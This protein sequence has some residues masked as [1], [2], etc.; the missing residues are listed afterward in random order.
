MESYPSML[1]AIPTYDGKILAEATNSLLF[2]VA[3]AQH[4][5]LDMAFTY[6][7]GCALVD[8]V[9]DSMAHTFLKESYQK[10]LMIDADIVFTPD[11]ILRILH[12]SRDYPIIGA[13]YPSRVELANGTSRYYLRPKD[14]KISY[15]KDG[16]LEVDGFGAGFLCVDK[17][18]FE[19]LASHVPQYSGGF[20]QQ[21][22]VAD[23]EPHHNFFPIG[24]D[25]LGAHHGE[26]YGFF[27]LA[28][29]YGFTPVVDLD[30]K[31]GH[32]GSKVYRGDPRTA[33]NSFKDGND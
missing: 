19:A 31:L 23:R 16:F 10:I 28:K 9:R 15:T 30:I 14:G 3:K 29:K 27:L 21:G 2:T 11:D 4:H 6:L 22:V 26:D 8:L 17:S 18:V 5:G 24:I 32:V 12:Y 25:A 1:I 7:S 20:V 13:T 33:I